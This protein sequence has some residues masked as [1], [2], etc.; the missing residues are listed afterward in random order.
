[1]EHVMNI[2]EGFGPPWSQRGK[3]S[4]GESVW[5]SKLGGGI[6]IVHRRKKRWVKK[7]THPTWLPLLRACRLTPAAPAID[8]LLFLSTLR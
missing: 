1:M 4:D 2:G 3:F 6:C 7:M 5:E 8:N